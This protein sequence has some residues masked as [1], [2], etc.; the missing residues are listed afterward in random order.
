MQEDLLTPS[1]Y[2]CLT[3]V[4]MTCIPGRGCQP[5]RASDENRRP[6][7]YIS[8]FESYVSFDAR[9][10]SSS[11]TNLLQTVLNILSSLDALRNNGPSTFPREATRATALHIN[12][13]A[14][15]FA[16]A[17]SGT[18][19]PIFCTLSDVARQTLAELPSLLNRHSRADTQAQES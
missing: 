13:K 16:E 6:Y 4:P 10:A 12:T 7:D 2:S 18:R 15:A 8:E 1:A 19:I 17:F 3:G 14:S 11:G 5:C 9:D